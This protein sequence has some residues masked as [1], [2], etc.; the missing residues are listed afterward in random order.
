MRD[1]HSVTRRRRRRRRSGEPRLRRRCRCDL[2]TAFRATHVE[3]IT[4]WLVPSCFVG[5]VIAAGCGPAT[6]A[7]KK[8]CKPLP[9]PATATNRKTL[10]AP[11]AS[12]SAILG[13]SNRPRRV[14]SHRLKLH[15]RGPERAGDSRDFDST[16][17]VRLEIHSVDAAKLGAL[18]QRTAMQR[19]TAPCG[20]DGA[21][22][23]DRSHLRLL[24]RCSPRV[25]VAC[26]N[27]KR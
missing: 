25:R 1:R 20:C 15:P 4:H 3:E 27:P 9:A 2:R 24:P 10:C 6:T 22:A 14:R 26:R 16:R 21:C 18:P 12:G 13:A 7:D 8:G 23:F 5:R 11:S 17:N 19:L